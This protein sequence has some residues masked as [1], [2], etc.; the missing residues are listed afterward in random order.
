MFVIMETEVYSYFNISEMSEI[1]A[2]LYKKNGEKALFL[3]PT[4][5]DKENLMRIIAADSSYFG[6]RPQIWTIGELYRETSK[7]CDTQ[8]RVIDPPDHNLILNY[9]VGRFLDEMASSGI[10][11]PAGIKHK[12]FIGVLGDNIKELLAEDV[13]PE[14]LKATLFGDG[15]YNKADAEA[16]LLRLYNDYLEYLEDNCLADAGQIPSLMKSILFFDK[17]RWANMRR[18]RV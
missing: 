13:T 3:V 4:S 7:L 9:L 12:G 17:M 10:E 11:L 14:H 18:F 8:R 16:L 6:S 2:D 5:L 15:E 1:L